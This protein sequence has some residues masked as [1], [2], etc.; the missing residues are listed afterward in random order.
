MEAERAGAVVDALARLARIRAGQAR[1]AGRALHLRNEPRRAA[2]AARAVLAVAR[3][4]A[5]PRAVGIAR[6][7][8]GRGRERTVR[9]ALVGAALDRGVGAGLSVGRCDRLAVIVP[10][11]CIRSSAT[12]NSR[13]RWAARR[14]GR[15]YRPRLRSRPDTSRCRRRSLDR[16]RRR[17]RAGRT[18]SASWRVSRGSRMARAASE[19]VSAKLQRIENPGAIGRRG[20][21]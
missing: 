2:E 20:G 7:H 19:Q 18:G 12:R 14:T 8:L 6:A 16:C 1:G 11:P 10:P 9:N 3:T 4:D 17:A 21:A 13:S 15:S 5:V